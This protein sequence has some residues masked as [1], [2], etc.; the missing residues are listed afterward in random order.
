MEKTILVIYV[1]NDLVREIDRF[2][3]LIKHELAN[4]N[5]LCFY[6]PT[7]EHE[8]YKIECI[9]PKLVSE[10][11]YNEVKELLEKTKN[12]LNNFLNKKI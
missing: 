4:S 10:V 1:N 6:V 9:N 5:I 3:E 2:N 8:Y 11:E 7:N 12:K